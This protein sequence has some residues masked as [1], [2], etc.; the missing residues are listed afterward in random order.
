MIELRTNK[1]D[2]HHNITISVGIAS[3]NKKLSVEQMVK[4]ADAALYCSKKNGRDQ[5]TVCGE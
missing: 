2:E 4:K 3:I 5:I 1:K